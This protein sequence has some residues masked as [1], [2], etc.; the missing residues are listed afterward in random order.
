WVAV[1]DKA[2]TDAAAAAATAQSRA[3]AT[4]T[5]LQS[6]DTKVTQQGNTISAQATQISQLT[7]TVNGVK[8]EISDVS[9]ALNSTNTKLSVY[10]TMRIKVDAN[11]R[12]YVAGMTQSIED[13]DSGMQSN[14][15]FLQD[16]FSIMN[17]AGGS[18]QLIFTTQGNQ[19]IINDVVIG[20][21]T[22]DGTKIKNATITGA[23]IKDL[24]VDF[25]K[26]T[27]TL[28]SSNFATGK[29]GWNLPKSGDAEL[30]SVTIRGKVY[31]TDGEFR[32]KLYAGDI[33][34]DIVKTSYGDFT[35]INKN[36]KN[37]MN[38]EGTIILLEVV[39]QDYEQMIVS[40]MQLY[41][42]Q[43]SGNVKIYWEGEDGTKNTVY[44]GNPNGNNYYRLNNIIVPAIGA[45]KKYTL[46][47]YNEIYRA[48]AQW[49][50]ITS[51]QVQS[52]FTI[53]KKNTSSIIGS[54]Y[55]TGV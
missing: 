53:Y 20:T 26:I 3:D 19:V 55:N 49:Q 21:A 13:T 30:N 51:D 52:Q 16:R 15:I 4:A 11:G 18:P 6:T 9:S 35:L 5:A 17:A 44:D 29:S 54:I 48:T 47:W 50:Y 45:N 1:T 2:A 32:G 34:G 23:N 22:I 12:S 39:G 33:I 10:R 42:K 14:T 43:S 46:K 8:T 24:S 7:S 36:L 37:P 38:S 40:N 31:A 28:R 27:D 25:A 41:F